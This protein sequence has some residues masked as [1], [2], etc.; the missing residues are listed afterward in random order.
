MTSSG[1]LCPSF[2][3]LSI[4]RLIPICLAIAVRCG[5]QLLEAPI[6]LATK[7][8][9]S[10]AS[11]VIIFEGVRSSCTISTILFPVSKEICS[12]SLYGA[13]IIALPVKDIPSA[14]AMEFIDDAVPIVL[15]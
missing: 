3:Q 13:G 6:A 8:A 10:K 15:Q 5:G 14:S 11:F 7:I 1:I 12:R 9:F 4:S 2:C